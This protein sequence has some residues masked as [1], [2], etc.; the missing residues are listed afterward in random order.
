MPCQQGSHEIPFHKGFS[1]FIH[2]RLSLSISKGVSVKFSMLLVKHLYL[3]LSQ[4]FGENLFLPC[5]GECFCLFIK[6]TKVD[7]MAAGA[8]V[9][10][11]G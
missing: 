3:L 9:D 11:K 1:S 6:K 4:H 7:K 5:L 10:G 8:G 2:C